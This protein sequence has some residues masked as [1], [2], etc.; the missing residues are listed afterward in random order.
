MVAADGLREVARQ[1]HHLLNATDAGRVLE[2]AVLEDHLGREVTVV[3]LLAAHVHSL[4][5]WRRPAELDLK[6][7]S[8]NARSLFAAPCSAACAAY[9]AP[10]GAPQACPA[11]LRERVRYEPSIAQCQSRTPRGGVQLRTRVA[12][13]VRAAPVDL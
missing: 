7:M 5:L 9:Q 10:A 8:I 2:G 13:T 1:P 12:R 11:L 6:R 3:E 4:Y